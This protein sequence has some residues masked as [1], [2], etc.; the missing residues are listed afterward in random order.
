M[1][2]VILK[3]PPLIITPRAMAPAMKM[4]FVPR[5]QGRLVVARNQCKHGKVHTGT[6]NHCHNSGNDKNSGCL[7]QQARSQSAE[8]AHH[9]GA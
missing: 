7:F 6:G 9:A 1:A 5:R 2:L 4:V 8:Q 3:K